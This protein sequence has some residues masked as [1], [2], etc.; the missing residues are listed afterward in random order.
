MM[1]DAHLVA[2]GFNF[3]GAQASINVWNPNVEREEDFT[4]AQMWLKTNNG[5]NFE[6]IESGWMVSHHLTSNSKLYMI[7][8]SVDKPCSHSLNSFFFY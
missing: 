6:S 1:Q 5:P 2:Y 4:T 3:I 8:S 7:N